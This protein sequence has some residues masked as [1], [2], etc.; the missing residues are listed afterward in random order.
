MKIA[1]VR[2]SAMGDIINSAFVLESIKK[3]YPEAQID[4]VCETVFAPLLE[5]HPYLHQVHRVNLK[6]LKKKRSLSM[7]LRTIRELKKVGPYDLVIDLQ[8]L[9]KS[10]LVSRFL[11][12]TRIGFDK[13]SIREAF[14]SRFYTKKVTIAYKENSIYRT[15][16][17]VSQALN[18]Q[19]ERQEINKKKRSLFYPK[20]QQL[21]LTLPK[22]PYLVIVSGSS[23]P[24]KNYPAEKFLQSIESLK[25]PALLVW[26]SDAERE[27]CEQIAQ[28]SDYA[29]LL[30]KLSLPQLIEIIDKAALTYGNDTGPTHIAWAL[31]RPSITLFGATSAKKL[32]WETPINVA[33]ESHTKKDPLH[34]DKADFSIQTIDPDIIVTTAQKLLKDSLHATH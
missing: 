25:I 3:A 10:A 19:I 11:G 30:P 14:A 31:N 16:Y 2:L 33:L 6:A 18:L 22:E 13:D 8:G 28:A 32:M 1:I 24:Y 34:I 17:L 7:L 20:T 5:T 12:K 4:W 27:V 21:P 23:M 9:I 29:R 15:A 26:G